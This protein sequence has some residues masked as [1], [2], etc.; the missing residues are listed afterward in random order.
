MVTP[1]HNTGWLVLILTAMVFA[2]NANTDSNML[3]TAMFGL[4]S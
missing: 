2:I 1:Y 4:S 3:A